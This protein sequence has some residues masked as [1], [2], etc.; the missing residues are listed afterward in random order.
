MVSAVMETRTAESMVCRANSMTL[1]SAGWS[2]WLSSAMETWAMA[3]AIFSG[4]SGGAR[5]N[6]AEAFGLF[7]EDALAVGGNSESP[8]QDLSE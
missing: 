5:S 2:S 7:I 6:T 3:A 1:A 8:E 4:V